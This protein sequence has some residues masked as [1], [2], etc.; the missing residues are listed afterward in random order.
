MTKLFLCSQP[1][2]Q[3]YAAGECPY[4]AYR[5]IVNP[6]QSVPFVRLCAS[7]N[8]TVY[9]RTVLH[10]P[11]SMPD[12]T[13]HRL[14]KMLSRCLPLSHVSVYTALSQNLLQ[15]M[16]NHHHINAD[17]VFQLF[18]HCLISAGSLNRIFGYFL[19]FTIFFT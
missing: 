8:I 15:Q 4:F 5:L 3:R 11:Q 2:L 9:L 19:F 7:P 17:K 14:M 6:E 18:L 12:L 16:H 1:V 10:I 13:I